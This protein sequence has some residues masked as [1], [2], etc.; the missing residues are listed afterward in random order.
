MKCLAKP[1]NVWR[2]THGSPD[3]LW[4]KAQKHFA[5]SEKHRHGADDMLFNVAV[6][7]PTDSKIHSP[8]NVFI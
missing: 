6:P 7:L 8:G 2:G 3:I 4:G 1:Q 5:Y